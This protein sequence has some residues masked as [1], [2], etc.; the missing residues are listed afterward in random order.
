MQAQQQQTVNE[1]ENVFATVSSK[2]KNEISQ[3]DIDPKE[4]SSTP[5][6]NREVKK[7]FDQFLEQQRKFQEQV[8]EK[9]KRVKK[10]L[11]ICNREN[12]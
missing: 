7:N 8:E 9:R 10:N 3:R 5:K 11:Q 4:Y 12:C 2:K 6:T 1:K